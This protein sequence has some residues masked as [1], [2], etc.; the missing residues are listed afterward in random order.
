M[1]MSIKVSIIVP[2]YKAERFL[3]RC[4]DSL[5]VQSVQNWEL[6]LID[7]GSP[8]NCGIICDEYAKKDS[9]INVIH[10]ENTGVSSA[11]NEGLNI[12]T[13]E[14]ICF[15]D[16][17]DYIEKS[18]LEVLGQADSDL[19]VLSAQHIDTE[20]KLLDRYELLDEIKSSGS[21]SVKEIISS[22]LDSPL[23]KTPWAKMFKRN[24]IDDIR[25]DPN[26]W[27]GED[28]LFLYE[29]LSKIDSIEI[30]HGY[31]YYWQTSDESTG[32]KYLLTPQQS[33]YIVERIY[34]AYKKIG[35]ASPKGEFSI[36]SYFFR[37]TDKSAKH[38]QM[39]IWYNSNVI[40]ALEPTMKQNL[41]KLDF[42]KYKLWEYPA[43][44]QVFLNCLNILCK[45]K[46]HLCKN[47]E[48]S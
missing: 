15:V 34:K 30:C 7:D 13:G 5:L 1:I 32:L 17:D 29:Y 26:I 40:K 2:V 8:D 27:I 22:H 19:I 21:E 42:V 28:T 4:I 11:R 38:R 16:A 36:I 18:Y 39:K 20:G 23:F 41:N 35:I 10:Q 3:Q 33:I 14:W 46:Q 44:E 6:I 9:R 25:F 12:A 37:I 48:H 47:D 24:I 31:M 45:I 43:L